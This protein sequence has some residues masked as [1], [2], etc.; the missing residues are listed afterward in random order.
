MPDELR[1]LL[2][3]DTLVRFA[4]GMAYVFFVLVITRL[5]RIGFDATVSVRGF[6]YAVDL[7]PEAFFG[8]LLGVEMLVTLLTM[9]PAATVAERVGLKPVVA[10]GFGVYVVFPVLLVYAPAT[11]LAM[12]L[13]FAF[14]GLRFAGLPSHKAFIVGPAEQDD[15]GRVT[16][17]DYLVRNVLVVPSAAV[18]GYLWQF[19]SP[20]TAFSVAAVV[21]LVGTGY[22]V[23]FDEEFDPYASR[24]RSD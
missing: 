13:V 18:G 11:E 17:T 15:S 23:A 7:S 8:Y 21:G 3:G 4:N 14:S 9:A 6:S 1:P 5:Y 2:V 24:S 20:Q 19:A 10:L 22:F 12:I 16:G